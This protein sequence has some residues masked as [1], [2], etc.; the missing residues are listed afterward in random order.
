M[1]ET[2][3]CSAGPQF[4]SPYHR[5]A[6]LSS[7]FLSPRNVPYNGTFDLHG[8]AVADDRQTY[9]SIIVLVQTRTKMRLTRTVGRFCCIIFGACWLRLEPLGHEP[10][11]LR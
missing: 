3:D 9:E 11:L 4:S 2:S 8:E 5:V 1:E 6:P 10:L 7:H